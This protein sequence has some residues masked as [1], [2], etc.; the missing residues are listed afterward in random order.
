MISLVSQPP[1]LPHEAIHHVPTDPAQPIL[2]K[3]LSEWQLYLC[4]LGK[5][6]I[7]KQ[8]G[9]SCS[10]ISYYFVV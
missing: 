8:L 7:F 4:P 5:T 10:V 2:Y 6:G 9:E 1:P 3:V